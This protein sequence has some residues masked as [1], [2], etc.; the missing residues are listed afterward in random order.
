MDI[1]ATYYPDCFYHKTVLAMN[2]EQGKTR[3]DNVGIMIS[4]QESTYSMEN[5]VET[6]VDNTDFLEKVKFIKHCFSHSCIIINE[7]RAP[8]LWNIIWR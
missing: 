6:W 3:T 5:I 1:E 2:I 4:G 8:Q 7:I